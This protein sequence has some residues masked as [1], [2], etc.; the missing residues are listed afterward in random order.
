MAKVKNEKRTEA[1]REHVV[2]SFGE[3]M[4]KIPDDRVQEVKV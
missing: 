1:G 4:M 3:S 2:P